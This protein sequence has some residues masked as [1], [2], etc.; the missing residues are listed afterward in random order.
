MGKC[1]PSVV[2]CVGRGA[3]SWVQDTLHFA[4]RS[5]GF[6]ARWSLMKIALFSVCKHFKSIRAE[7]QKEVRGLD[8]LA[9]MHRL[10]ETAFKGRK[11]MQEEEDL[12][13]G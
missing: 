3:L 12:Q 9:L 8:L 7:M 13:H 6:G 2:L 4:S 10:R 1:F 11:P 5:L